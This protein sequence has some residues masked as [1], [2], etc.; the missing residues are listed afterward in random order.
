MEEVENQ[1]IFR[2]VMLA[3]LVARSMAFMQENK[4]YHHERR[5]KSYNAIYQGNAPSA[6]L[7]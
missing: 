2:A 5:E 7:E 3:I 6:S 4:K 1:D